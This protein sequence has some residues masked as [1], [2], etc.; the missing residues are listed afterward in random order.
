MAFAL[1]QARVQ[2]P[3]GRVS[4]WARH[5]R[6][7]LLDAAGLLLVVAV[8]RQGAFYSPDVVVL[9]GLV[10]L[11]GCARAWG[12][13]CR[14][15][16]WETSACLFWSILS[17]VYVGLAAQHGDALAAE[18]AVGCITG[19]VAGFILARGVEPTEG[20]VWVIAAQLFSLVTSSVAFIGFS[21]RIYPLALPAQE[22]FRL[23]GTLTY[24]NATGALLVLLLVFLLVQTPGRLRDVAVFAAATALIATQSRGA[25]LGIIV[26]CAFLWI[27]RLQARSLGRPLLLA[28]ALGGWS[29]LDSAE[30][31]GQRW[32]VLA[33]LLG[34]LAQL[35]PWRVPT[36][37]R[38]WFLVAVAVAGAP[39]ALFILAGPRAQSVLRGR[40]G[41]ASVS[42][43]SYEWH[44]AWTS[45]GRNV[46]TGVGP[47]QLLHL[48]DGRTA[49]FVHNEALQVVVDVGLLGG[50][51]AAAALVA[52]FGASY[53]AGNR[54]GVAAALG[55][56]GASLFDFPLHLAAITMV[57]GLVLGVSGWNSGGRS[58][59][60]SGKHPKSGCVRSG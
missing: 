6:P 17:L 20:M 3:G 56:L 24:S 38:R 12:V 42:D 60:S 49:V 30:A 29:V 14:W 15:T 7:R 13:A 31:R 8:L 23:A 40:L 26:G 46:W 57:A 45:I 11:L 51:V 18:R 10:L 16:R 2:S 4:R 47:G 52:T 54:V 48:T 5:V 34:L 25:L 27:F 55:L 50:V 28:V 59:G 32:L 33:F 37:R 35:P 22:H 53:R 21:L 43:R 58:I 41:T 1:R 9:P 39:A 19:L 44:A 36:T